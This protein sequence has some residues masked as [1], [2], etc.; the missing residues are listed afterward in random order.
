MVSVRSWY[1][2]RDFGGVLLSGRSAWLNDVALSVTVRKGGPHVGIRDVGEA[3]PQLDL[4]IGLLR[5]AVKERIRGTCVKRTDD[6][7]RRR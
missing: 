4:G 2:V 6:C 7:R 1:V 5:E 3:E